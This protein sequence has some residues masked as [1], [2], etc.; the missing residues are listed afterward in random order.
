MQPIVYPIADR[1][2][3]E[4]TVD[5]AWHYGL[6][7]MWNRHDDGTWWAQV[8]W[9]RAPGETM[10]GTFPASRVRQVQKADRPRQRNA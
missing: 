2:D 8:Q 3:G 9:S 6:L 4:V 1:P 10:L 5:G 7:R